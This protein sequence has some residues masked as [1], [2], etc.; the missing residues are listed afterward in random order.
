VRELFSREEVVAA[1]YDVPDAAAGY[2][3]AHA[4]NGPE[5]RFFRS[6]L[7]AVS[8]VLAAVPGG[9]LLDVGCGPGIM[10]REL[11]NTRPGDFRITALDR[12]PVMVDACL[13][14][15]GEH[16]VRAVVGRIE[17]MDFADASFDVTLAMGSLEYTDIRHSLSELARV[18]RP[19]GL[20][21]VSMLNP[22]SPYR[23]V[24]WHVY[25]PLLRFL[26][27]LEQVLT[28][29]SERRHRAE[30]DGIRAYR[31]GTLRRLMAEARLRTVSVTYFDT[32][33]FVPPADR[34]FRRWVRLNR[35]DRSI[36]RRWRGLG[37]GYLI[38]A[39]PA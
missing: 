13:R 9:E 20:V 28:V 39:R 23:F 19:G 1:Q 24:E 38:A 15:A 10:V 18:T 34:L 26:G 3:R 30:T 7:H 22:A 16:P 2:A 6:R 36:A 11:L 27:R 8:R 12:S 31:E 17:R 32:T 4:G 35:P 14:R 33:L 21:L 29:P 5:A 37:T 25:R